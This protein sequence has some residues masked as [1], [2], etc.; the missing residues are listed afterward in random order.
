MESEQRKRKADDITPAEE[1]KDTSSREQP[2]TDKDED[3]KRTKLSSLENNSK[4]V[5]EKEENGKTAEK[6]EDAGEKKSEETPETTAP[7][8]SESAS[9]SEKTPADK[10]STSKN[11]KTPSSDDKEEKKSVFGAATGFSGFATVKPGGGFGIGNKNDTSSAFGSAG[12]GGFGTSA[13]GSSSLFGSSGTKSGFATLSSGSIMGFGTAKG[14][15]EIQ[16]SSGSSFGASAANKTEE[17]TAADTTEASESAPVRPIVELPTNYEI[18]SGEEEEIVLFEARCRTHRLVPAGSEEESITNPTA[19]PATASKAA[20]AVPP[21]QSLVGNSTTESTAKSEITWREVGLGP[22]RALQHGTSRKIRLVQRREVSPSGPATKVIV[23]APLHCG[24]LT[25]IHKPTEKHV[26]WTTP[27]E[28]KAV[29]Y[30]FK[31][32]SP[33]DATELA[34]VLQ[35]SQV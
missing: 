12:G 7:I 5:Q 27:V 22:L 23:N 11:E 32:G 16:G 29:T 3:V 24:G 25:K 6:D 28:G 26:Q 34:K 2:A 20:P 13:S 31:F 14:F 17:D 4:P 35:D 9:P 8:Q 18:R 15:G 30:L 19:A 33:Q 10:G 1:Q 21:S